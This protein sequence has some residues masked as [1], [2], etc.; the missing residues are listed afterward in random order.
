MVL[1]RVRLMFMRSLVC[2]GV[3]D[4][5]RYTIG[6]AD[7]RLRYPSLHQLHDQLISIIHIF[8]TVA[9]N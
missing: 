1:G 2:E 4:E 3:K 7:P 9:C 6:G 8:Y 5:E